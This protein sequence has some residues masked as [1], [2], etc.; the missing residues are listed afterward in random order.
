MRNENKIPGPGS[1]IEI[2][3]SICAI[4]DP[5]T[6]CGLSLYVKDGKIIKVEGDKDQ[7]YGQGT[8]CPKGAATR[9]YVYSD[10]RIKTPL[11]RVGE[12]GEG[13]FEAISWDEAMNEIAEKLGAVKSEYG[14]E[15]VCF[16][17]GFSKYYRPWL[18]RLCHSFGSP[19]Y[20][21]ESST[22]FQAM[23]LSQKLVF[24]A[25]G[26]PDMANA[27]CLI[28]W[29][30]N[31]FHTNPGN[32][33]MLTKALDRGMK[34]IVV[35][36]RRTPTTEKADIH[37]RLRPGTDGAL[38]LAM[39]NVI[40]SENLYDHDFV[41][42]YTNGFE[43][44]KKYVSDFTPEKGE[45]LTGVPAGQIREAAR[46]F[47][48]VKPG[49][50]MPSASPVVHHTNGV[51]NYRA[52]FS[53]VGLTG[54]Y[55]IKGGQFVNP[56]SIH[57]MAGLLTT[58]VGQFMQS[59]PYSE[60][61]E[62]MD[63]QRFPVWYQIT[64]EEAQCMPLP[65]QIRTGKPYPIRAIVG[66]GLNF[67]MWPDSQGMRDALGE[68]DFFVNTDLFMTE[69]CK[70]ADIVLPAC[71]TVE[72]S[73]FR[74]WPNGYVVYTTP[75]IAPLYDSRSDVDI[76]CDMA[77]H[78]CPEDEQLASGHEATLQWILEPSGLK[79]EELK[80]HPSGM[81]N[82]NPN[83]L[84]EK[85]YLKGGFKTPSGKL[86]FVSTVMAP[87]EKPGAEVLPIYTPPKYSPE[88][89]PELF[90]DYPLILNTGSRLPMFVHTRTYR[91][92][93]TASLR[94]DHPSADLNPADAKK[95]NISQGDTI[96]IITPK[97]TITVK[98]NLTQMVLPGVVHM[99]HGHSD[100]DVNIL[101]EWDY[102]DPVSGFPGFK[103]ALCRV[104]REG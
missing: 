83:K 62:R 82:P 18:K 25:P 63:K 93:W 34:L 80:K 35:D 70:W 10:D 97:G 11:R 40:I 47:A 91:L 96:R 49:G 20:A 78:I 5:T 6:Q 85:K 36:P 24:G 15:A 64:Q 57:H 101:L 54:N 59:K 43:D 2:C 60:M 94:P 45:L 76:I 23:A 79:L 7:P 58:R 22:C 88:G 81:F 73:E 16:F 84:D 48:T 9:Q 42:N 26:A 14:P 17:S 92:P 8:L 28:I 71:T 74:C 53:L 95:Q 56:P 3:K 89:S 44:Y 86:E 27:K 32:A 19:N 68:L 77:K 102:L 98:A 72:R 39:A 87:F 51:Q 21:S 100:A 75:A 12:R 61:N 104:E 37:L 4:C 90:K 33:R 29:S 38:A 46:M 50:V 66:F 103:S 55:D 99:Y 30:A 1:G 13:K 67:R 65:E 52:I 69:S 31:P 41:N